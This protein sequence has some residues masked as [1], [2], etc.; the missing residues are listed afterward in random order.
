MI[1]GRCT[2]S[3]LSKTLFIKCLVVTP[4]SEGEGGIIHLWY[5]CC[6]PSKTV[7]HT[8][9]L[10][11]A[12]LASTPVVVLRQITSPETSG[13]A[14]YSIYCDGGRSS[15]VRATRIGNLMQGERSN[16]DHFY[17]VLRC[18]FLKYLG[19]HIFVVSPP[20]RAV[21]SRVL[22]CMQS[23][24]IFDKLGCRIA[25]RCLVRVPLTSRHNTFIRIISGPT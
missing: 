18:E 14:C 3:V 16:H 21:P 24:T 8:V 13:H 1:F 25:P 22:V 7:I 19:A 10:N 9:S 12:V 15:Q 17:R 5:E 4:L 20:F 23:L 6:I 2:R 11:D